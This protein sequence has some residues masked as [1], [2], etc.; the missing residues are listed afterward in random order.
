VEGRWT[1]RNA[2]GRD[3]LLHG[4][5][6]EFGCL[7]SAPLPDGLG[8]GES[9][10]LVVRCRAPRRTGEAVRE[11]RL[12]SSDPANPEIALPFAMTVVGA[13]ADPAALYFGSVR[14]GDSVTRE[15]ALPVPN[16]GGSSPGTPQSNDP[17]LSIEP[18]PTRHDGRLV[19]R[20]TFH[21]DRVGTLHASLALGSGV[22]PVE[23]IGVAFDE[24]LVFPAQVEVPSTITGDTPLPVTLLGVGSEPITIARVEYPAGLAGELHRGLSGRDFRLTLRAQRGGLVPGETAGRAI[25]VYG[26][27][28]ETLAV[29]PVVS[30]EE[31]AAQ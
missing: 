20:V 18:T 26:E 3:L 21:P 11:L 14:V 15:V 27:A 16:A 2:G 7:P 13:T 12:L 22:A 9:F 5:V 10:A 23:V 19:Y 17:T 24:I 28:G 1:L 8:P 31:R 30:P 6:P 25:R 4:L 29:I